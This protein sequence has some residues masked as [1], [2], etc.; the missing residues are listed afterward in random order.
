[1]ETELLEPMLWKH[2][3]LYASMWY[4]AD[5]P[6]MNDLRVYLLYHFP[7]PPAHVPCACIWPC[8]ILHILLL[9]FFFASLTFLSSFTFNPSLISLIFYVL[10]ARLTFASKYIFHT[11][12][13]KWKWKERKKN[14]TNWA[15][16]FNHIYAKEIE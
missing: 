16:D 9:V 15:S 3:R 10:A 8:F 11:M 5:F 7:W 2:G 4:E 12:I 13:Q 6:K 1:M 14:N